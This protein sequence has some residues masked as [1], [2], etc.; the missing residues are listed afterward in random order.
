VVL[1]GTYQTG[2]T[3]A[4][5]LAVW[6][7]NGFGFELNSRVEKPANH[8]KIVKTKQNQEFILVE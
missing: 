6:Q 5:S 4:N 2:N 1:E 8:F 7:W 3:S